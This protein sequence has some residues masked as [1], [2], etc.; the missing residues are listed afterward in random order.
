M[1]NARSA[2][3]VKTQ[4]HL[5]SVCALHEGSCAGLGIIKV[6]LATDPHMV[7]NSLAPHC[8]AVGGV[9]GGPDEEWSLLLVLACSNK[10]ALGGGL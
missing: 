4:I 8:D 9:P 5:G 10:F 6:L 1:Q 2:N 7:L 3:E